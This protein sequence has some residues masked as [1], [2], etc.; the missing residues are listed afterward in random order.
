MIDFTIEISSKY[1]NVM[2][3]MSTSLVSIDNSFIFPSGEPFAGLLFYNIKK[4]GSVQ[5]GL[6]V[7][8]VT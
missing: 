5:A 7:L 1:T 3:K 8:Y 4:Y 2:L 6:N